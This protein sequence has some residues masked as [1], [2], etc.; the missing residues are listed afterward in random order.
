MT[1]TRIPIDTSPAELLVRL[2]CRSPARSMA[3]PSKRAPRIPMGQPMRFAAMLAPV[4]RAGRLALGVVVVLAGT[5]AAMA[6]GDADPDWPCIQRLVPRIAEA[7]VWAGPEL[8]PEAWRGDREI[9]QLASDL[10][11]RR[12]SLED[13]RAEIAAFANALPETDRNARL[14]A[15]F[16]R[17]LEVINRDRASL[18]AGIKRFARNQR[19]LAERIRTNLDRLEV[20]E[21]DEG[22][23]VSDAASS[24]APAPLPDLD[25]T[26][27]VGM[28]GMSAD[29]IPPQTLTQPVGEGQLDQ[30]R[31]TVLWETRIYAERQR[32]LIYLCEQPVLLDQRA[33]AI[34]S[35]AA[36]HL[37]RN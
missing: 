15:L 2:L 35:A 3:S 5:N 16:G 6:A 27:A 17:T 31:Q 23:S 24:T 7:A 12:L 22:R 32:S 1:M 25:V 11:A 20:A 9:R 29:I 13:A 36:G 37:L 26:G 34:G 21:L 4:R 19:A 33:F 28:P 14:T 10:A 18:L 30:L 8:D